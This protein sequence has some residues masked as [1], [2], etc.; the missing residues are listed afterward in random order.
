MHPSVDC[1]TIDSSQNMK[2]CIYTLEYYSA[3]KRDEITPFVATWMI[4]ESVILS[5]VSQI[6]THII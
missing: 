1:S 6:R 5:E 3:M 2:W 4:L